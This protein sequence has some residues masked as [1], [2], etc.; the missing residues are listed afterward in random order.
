MLKFE[1]DKIIAETLKDEKL[2]LTKAAIVAMNEVKSRTP[3]K[4]G[5]L[6]NSI[7]YKVS[8]NKATIGTNVEYAGDVEYGLGHNIERAMFRKAIDYLVSNKIIE[9][10][11]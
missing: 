6:K 11:V 5:L 1:G 4:T 2:F 9:Q 10:L 3:V 8:G 7:S